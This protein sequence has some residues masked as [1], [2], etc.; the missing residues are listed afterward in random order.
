MD[1]DR[2]A[3]EKFQAAVA[4]LCLERPYFATAALSLRPVPVPPEAG[5]ALAAV[6]DDW[7]VYIAPAFARLGVV[8]AAAV[9]QHELEHLLRD[10]ASRLRSVDPHIL[11]N[12]AAD[13]EI[14]DDLVRSWPA[15]RWDQ[16][17]PVTPGKFGL[18]EGLTAEEYVSLLRKQQ[19]DA[20][21]QSQTGRTNQVGQA[22]PSGQPGQPQSGQPGQSGQPEKSAGAGQDK[23]AGQQTGQS[24]RGPSG[25]PSPP[26]GDGN[27]AAPQEGMDRFEGS[28]ATGRRGPWEL[29]QDAEPKGLS[30]HGAEA[31]RLATAKA[32]LEE[33]GRQRGTVPSGLTKWARR[34]LSGRQVNWS[35]ILRAY[36]S[37]ALDL[38][39]SAGDERSYARLSRRQIPGIL[40]PGSAQPEPIVAVVLDT[41]ASMGEMGVSQAVAQI[42]SI[43]AQTDASVYVLATDAAVH[44]VRRVF[45]ER[46]LSA[47]FPGGGG[48][49]MSVGVEQALKL[50][51]RPDLV[52]VMTDGYTDWPSVRPPVPVVVCLV[53]RY[54]RAGVPDWAK[55]VEVK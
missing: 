49:E 2:A 19:K 7:R 9:L 4:R 37:Q 20:S 10:H 45:D 23:K 22:S 53:G 27:T 8:E 52:I 33:A 48:T 36:I 6:G 21:G 41:S 35:D 16:L 25:K 24:G 39:A 26:G 47:E 51:P 5:I 1:R 46:D 12:M 44:E 17:N 43:L 54:T 42:A 13:M 50:T 31:V 14:N 29:P 40:L 28:G 38:V 11:A 30:G 32:I 18:P 3:I 34:Q 15:A 55:V